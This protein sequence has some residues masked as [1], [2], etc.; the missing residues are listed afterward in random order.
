MVVSQE[1]G[2]FV[3]KREPF[4]GGELRAAV[5]HGDKPSQLFCQVQ[6]RLGVVACAEDP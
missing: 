6:E 2:H 3:G 4:A 5:G 1:D